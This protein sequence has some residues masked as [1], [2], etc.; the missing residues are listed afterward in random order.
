VRYPGQEG[1]V[2]EALFSPLGQQSIRD[3]STEAPCSDEEYQVIKRQF[4]YDRTSLNAVVEHVD[5]S[6]PFWRKEK[7]TFD[8]AYDGER[9][10]AFLFLPRSVE[11]PYQVVVYWPAGGTSKI[12]AFTSLPQREWTEYIITGG[13][14]LLFPVYKG[15]FER[16]LATWPDPRHT[17]L[18]FRDLII[19]VS[20][21]MQRSIDYLETRDD[22]DKERIAYYGVSGGATF[23]PL[24]LAEEDRFNAAI[25]VVGGFYTWMELP[26]A[27]DPLNHAPRVNTPVLMVNGKEDFY[28]PVE[29]SQVPMFK[30]LGTPDEDKD[31]K[32][33][34]GGHGLLGLF[35]K[36]IRSDMH[37]WLDRYLGPVNG[38]KNDMK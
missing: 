11:P 25:L 19:Q 16:R 14:A 1:S 2:S 17:P 26:A 8:A 38:T 23:G 10:I 7:I 15:M 30:L 22:I 35:S 6:S 20:K 32:I 29:T 28:F 3:Y 4:D 9:V 27:V 18:K 36:Q 31:H 12:P 13:R 34:P 21:D 33:Y 37:T 5:D 24:V